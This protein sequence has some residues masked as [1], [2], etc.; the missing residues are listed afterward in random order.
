M[1]RKKPGFGKFRD[2]LVT[3]SQSKPIES[4]TNSTLLK[5]KDLPEKTPNKICQKCPHTPIDNT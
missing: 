5:P 4:A 1:E 2:S 3:D